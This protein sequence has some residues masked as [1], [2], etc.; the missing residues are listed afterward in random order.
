[1]SCAVNWTLENLAALEA[2][3][4]DGALEVRYDD[5]M[6]RYRTLAEMERLR[7]RMRIALC[8]DAV[9]GKTAG[10]FGKVFAKSDK[11]LG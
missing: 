11:A 5:K 6:V 2:A 8:D 7:N 9:E 1:M 4:A 10:R 3:L